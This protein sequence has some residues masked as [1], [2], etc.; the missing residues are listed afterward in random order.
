M[1]CFELFA[2]LSWSLC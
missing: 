1:F 2:L